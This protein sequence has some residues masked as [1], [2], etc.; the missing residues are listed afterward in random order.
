[1]PRADDLQILAIRI[2]SE[3]RHL[4][5]PNRRSNDGTSSGKSAYCRF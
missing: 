2:A 3:G 5:A 1:M 4:L